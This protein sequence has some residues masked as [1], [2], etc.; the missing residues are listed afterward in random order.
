MFEPGKMKIRIVII[1]GCL[2]LLASIGWVSRGEDAWIGEPHAKYK[3][4]YKEGDKKT[5]EE[6]VSFLDRGIEDV[7]SFTGKKYTG[8]FSVYVHPDRGSMD[9]QWSSDWNMPG[10]KSECWMVASGVATKLDLLSPLKWSAEACEHS[11]S[12]A[13]KTQQLITHEL[14]HVY[15]GQLNESPDFSVADTIDWFV[16]GF[17]TYAS[18]QCD[19]A[20]IRQV[21]NAIWF[22]QVPASLSEFWTGKL[23]YGLAGSMVM[24]IDHKYGRK[25]VLEMLLYNKKTDILNT[26]RTDEAA[27]IAGWK[28]YM[29][30]K[31]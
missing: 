22:N 19:T 1:G 30:E 31:K 13:E 26:L 27:L 17:A 6:Y 10:F 28:K 21:R 4:H 11:Y 3:L 18:G 8:V 24:Y 15:H 2:V 12:N 20:R 5:K 29:Q 16:E 7:E 9:K 23:K 14:F 25:K